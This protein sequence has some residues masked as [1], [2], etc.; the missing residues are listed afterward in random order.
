MDVA[1]TKQLK[2]LESEKAK[3]KRMLSEQ[4][5]VIGA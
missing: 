1:P 5:L 4:L 2:K 3:L